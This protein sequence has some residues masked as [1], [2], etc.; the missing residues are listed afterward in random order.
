MQE[1]GNHPRPGGRPPDFPTTPHWASS[2]PSQTWC[3]SRVSSWP[4]AN[5]CT[6][7]CWAP[8]PVVRTPD[9]LRAVKKG[10][11]G[12]PDRIELVCFNWRSPDAVAPEAGA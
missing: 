1:L 3:A 8:P 10:K 11:P 2:S 4:R 12:K 6:S 7:T 5:S 9:G